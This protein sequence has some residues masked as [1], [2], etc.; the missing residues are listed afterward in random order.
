MTPFHQRAVHDDDDQDGGG[1]SGDCCLL[2]RLVRLRRRR[3]R[4]RRHRH[5]LQDLEE[6][7]QLD[8]QM[9]VGLLQLVAEVS[10]AGVDG[11]AAYLKDQDTHRHTDTQRAINKWTDTYQLP[12]RPRSI[13]RCGQHV[14]WTS[15][16]ATTLSTVLYCPQIKLFPHDRMASAAL[17]CT[18]FPTRLSRATDVV[19][20]LTQTSVTPRQ[21][22]RPGCRSISSLMTSSVVE[23]A[24]F[25]IRN[26]I[27]ESQLIATVDT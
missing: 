5:F 22:A 19:F 3:R 18:P 1:G 12:N 2:L 13:R 9:P 8:H 25:V 11:F 10:L 20:P 27:R 23:L 4:R 7:L 14:R 15:R 24:C 26:P 17:C 6:L 21:L 16:R